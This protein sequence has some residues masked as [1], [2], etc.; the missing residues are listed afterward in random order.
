MKQLCDRK[1]DIWTEKVDV[2]NYT[3]ICY[4]VF[5]RHIP[6]FGYGGRIRRESLMVKD[7]ICHI[8]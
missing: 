6:F 8:I 3:M 1:D 4:E 2:Y 7:L 5:T